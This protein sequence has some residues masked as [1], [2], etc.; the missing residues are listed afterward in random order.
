MLH[1][2]MKLFYEKNKNI[3]KNRFSREFFKTQHK[4]VMMALKRI[5]QTQIKCLINVA[6]PCTY[7]SA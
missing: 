2:K 5:K 7:P 4:S 1:P 3:K 6:L